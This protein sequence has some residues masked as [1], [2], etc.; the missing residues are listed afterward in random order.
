MLKSVN[1]LFNKPLAEGILVQNETSMSILTPKIAQFRFFLKTLAVISLI[2][3]ISGFRGQD[4]V[5][6]SS[7][8]TK[9]KV[10]CL[11]AGHGGRDPGTTGVTGK[12]EKDAALKIVLA[13]GEKIKAEFPEM[14]VIYTRMKDVKIDLHERSAIANRNQAD[15][16]VSVHCNWHPSS[17]FKGT[18][19]YTMGLHKTNDNLAVAKRENSVILQE[20]DYKKTYKGFD[21]KS[22]LGHIMLANFQNAFMT[23]SLRLAQ[24]V[25]RQFRKYSDRNS[26]GVK[27]AGFLVLWETAMPSILV[28]AG[29]VSNAE[30][31]EYLFSTKGQEGVAESIFRA[32]KTYKE[33]MEN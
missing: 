16:F 23:N 32:F 26:Y 18:E 20:A 30:E 14:K 9:I 6:V 10:I 17:K 24:K 22:P 3:I 15:L 33:E 8:G 2:H 12:H 27:Q 5:E 11:D 13:L 1:Y 25:E 29:F 21:P 31:E 28:E 7:K 19:T 4:E